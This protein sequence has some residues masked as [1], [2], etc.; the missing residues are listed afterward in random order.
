MCVFV[1]ILVGMDKGVAFI[2]DGLRFCFVLF[3][4]E[5]VFAAAVNNDVV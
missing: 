3:K 5:T 4:K 1:T 2:P